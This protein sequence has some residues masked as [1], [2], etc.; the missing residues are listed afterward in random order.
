M[1]G[2]L[3]VGSGSSST[4]AGEMRL[5]AKLDDAANKKIVVSV[6]GARSLLPSAPPGGLFV[7]GAFVRMVRSLARAAAGHTYLFPGGRGACEKPLKTILRGPLWGNRN[8]A[9]SCKS[10]FL[11]ERSLLFM[12]SYS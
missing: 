2:H 4:G 8:G 11:V 5:K 1:I 3:R 12:T 10:F 6:N 9:K 7:E